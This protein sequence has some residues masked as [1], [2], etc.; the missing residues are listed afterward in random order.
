MG[1]AREGERSL[2]EL[3]PALRRAGILSTIVCLRER[4]EGVQDEVIRSGVDVRILRGRTLSQL[5]QLRRIIRDE[6]PDLITRRSSPPTSWAVSRRRIACRR[7]LESGEHALC[8]R[9]SPGS[10]G[11]EDIAGGRPCGRRDHRADADGSLPRDHARGRRLGGA[12]HGT[13]RLADHGDR[14]WS[15]SRS[16]RP[17]CR[18]A[19]PRSV[20]GSGSRTRTRSSSLSGDRS[21]RRATGTSSK[22]PRRS[23]RPTHDCSS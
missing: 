10:G 9:P 20:G 4:R 12:R 7:P 6:A 15:G 8:G 3:Q 17:P 1:W 18:G 14:A 2:A 11:S 5:L 16:P 19:T 22:R 23:A 13:R 21:S